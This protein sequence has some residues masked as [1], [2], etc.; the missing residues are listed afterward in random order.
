MFIIETKEKTMR[1]L[2]LQKTTII[3]KL[4]VAVSLIMVVT[5][6]SSGRVY[7]SRA[8]SINGGVGSICVTVVGTDVEGNTIHYVSCR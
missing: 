1:E 8:D 7:A 6:I 5:A 4:I 2:A 3:T